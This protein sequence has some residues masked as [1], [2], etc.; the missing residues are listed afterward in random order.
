MVDRFFSPVQGTSSC[1]YQPSLECPFCLHPV[2]AARIQFLNE[3]IDQRVF[4]LQTMLI[5]W[6]K[7]CPLHLVWWWAHGGTNIWKS[8]IRWPIVCTTRW[9][10]IG[11]CNCLDRENLEIL[12]LS[13]Q[14]VFY[15]VQFE[16][17]FWSS[18][19]QHSVEVQTC[20]YFSSHPEKTDDQSHWENLSNKIHVYVA[21]E[22]LLVQQNNRGIW[23]ERS[24]YTLP[25]PRM[26]DGSVVIH[27]EKLL[28]NCSMI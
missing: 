2:R 21:E 10:K 20:R 6:S 28:C 23:V 18:V 4:L 13:M 17:H 27:F 5:S 7:Q 14:P 22:E 9:R 11:P 24:K 16:K 1:V 8:N 26:H 3:C 15:W 19:L 25:V 12:A